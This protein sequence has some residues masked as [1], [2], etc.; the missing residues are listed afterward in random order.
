VIVEPE[1]KNTAAAIALAALQLHADSV[2][3]VCP[4]DHHIGDVAAFQAAAHEAAKLAAKGSAGFVRHCRHGARNRLRLSEARRPDP[5]E[6]WL[7]RRAIVEKPDF[8]RA[9]GFL[10]D[11]G[12]A[13]MAVSLRSAQARSSMNS[14]PIAPLSLPLFADAA[15]QGCSEG[16]RFHPNAEAFARIEGESVD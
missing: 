10:A 5:R 16:T 13:G 4:S 6:R 12:H 9:I 2:M 14:Q 11:G 15:L 3:L 7:F 8:Q 1:G